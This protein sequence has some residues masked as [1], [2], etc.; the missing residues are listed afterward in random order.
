M[1]IKLQE[2]L[3]LVH[4][5]DF[6]KLGSILLQVQVEEITGDPDNEVLYVKW[7]DD[8]N[9]FC[10]K[11]PEKLNSEIER[12]GHNLIFFDTEGNP[13]TVSLFR[14]TAILA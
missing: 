4:S 7:E 13:F 6:V 2:A 9:E 10:L 5:A 12:S 14:E 1:K 11:A 3:D 8:Y